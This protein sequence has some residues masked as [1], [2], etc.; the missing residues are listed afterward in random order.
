MKWPTGIGG[1][2]NEGVAAYVKQIKGAHRL[3]RTVLRAAEQDGATPRM[4]NAAGNWVHAERRELRRRRRQRRLGERQGLLPGHHQCAGRR[5][6]A[7]HRDQLHPDVQA[8]EERRR[9]AKAAIDFFRW[10]YENGDAQAK[11]LDYVP[12]PAALVAADRGVLGRRIQVLI[13]TL[14]PDA[15]TRRGCALSLCRAARHDEP[16]TR[17]RP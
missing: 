13:S 16:G 5:L 15:R 9:A 10:A 14:H 6:L 8:A 12:L 1:K 3:R 7:D 17:D 11:A 4:Q 2:G